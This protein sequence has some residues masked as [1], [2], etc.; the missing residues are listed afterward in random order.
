MLITKEEVMSE[1]PTPLTPDQLLPDGQDGRDINGTYV[2]KGTV[3]A[4][5]QNVKSLDSAHQGTPEY[6]ALVD[7]ITAAKPMLDA[8]EIFA[9]FEV[10]DPQIAALFQGRG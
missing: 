10:R 9:V 8:L 7:Q 6:D 3:G 4:F 2:R 1:S 5:I